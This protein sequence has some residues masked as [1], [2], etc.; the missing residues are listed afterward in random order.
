MTRAYTRQPPVVIVKCPCASNAAVRRIRPAIVAR[1]YPWTIFDLQGMPGKPPERLAAILADGRVCLSAAG[2][3]CQ[4]LDAVRT[5]AASFEDPLA[6][7]DYNGALLVDSK[8]VR[9]RDEAVQFGD[10]IDAIEAM[11]RRAVPPDEREDGTNR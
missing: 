3:F 9:L 11:L 6:L 4:S 7:R 8:F 1:H 5:A 10:V 2:W